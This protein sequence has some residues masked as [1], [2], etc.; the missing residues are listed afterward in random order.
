MCLLLVSWAVVCA[1]GYRFVADVT[2]PAG[3]E[4][5]YITILDNPTSEAGIE[6]IITHQLIAEFTRRKPRLLADRRAVADAVLSG[7]ISSIK[8]STVSRRGQEIPNER[9]IELQL[10][11]KLTSADGDEL[12]RARSLIGS[13]AYVIDQTNS[14]VTQQ[15]KQAAVSALAEKIAERTYDGLTQNY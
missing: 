8:I 9:R 2:L 5:I 1:C 14:L 7:A 10:D 15:N 6:N 13:Q 11:I 3:V 12:W 4:H